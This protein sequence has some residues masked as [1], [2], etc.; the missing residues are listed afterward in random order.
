MMD[1]MKFIGYIDE[2]SNNSAIG[3]A[4]EEIDGLCY[5][6]NVEITLAD[7][8]IFVVNPLLYRPDLEDVGI[9]SGCFGFKF[10]LEAGKTLAGS[11]FKFINGETIPFGDNAKTAGLEELQDVDPDF[12]SG[13]EIQ[14]PRV[15]DLL[16]LNYSSR[17]DHL[18]YAQSDID[19]QEVKT[20]K[21]VCIYVTYSNRLYV[22]N[23]QKQQIAALQEA[24]YFV[25][26]VMA[27]DNYTGGLH[28]NILGDLTIVKKNVGYDFGSWWVGFRAITDIM[29]QEKENVTHIALCNDSFFGAISKNEIQSIESLNG[30]LVGLVDSYQRSHH[31][32]S[33]FLIAKGLYLQS[34]CFHNFISSYP[35]PESKDNVILA[36]EIGLSSDVKLSGSDLAAANNYF[37]LISL[38]VK[39]MDEMIEEEISARETFGVGGEKA[40][41]EK[42]FSDFYEYIKS[43]K[44]VNP[45]HAFWRQIYFSGP[46]IIKRELLFKDP[47]D[48]PNWYSCCMHCI[49][50]PDISL[51]MDELIS[52]LNVSKNQKSAILSGLLRRLNAGDHFNPKKSHTRKG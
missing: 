25:V 32:Q 29:S 52:M 44:I 46:K 23:Y 27:V 13:S 28:G 20:V 48:L 11:T 8:S 3:W 19:L 24:G 7:G 4:V 15:D 12:N 47:M 37:E 50:S 43:G 17:L 49:S 51:E 42:A 9:G 2:I 30:G 45:T 16:S 10:E 18:I 36:G 31:L 38:W 5:D 14:L 26:V 41:I 39:E 34:G 35:F 21:K 6:T 40:D 1:D 22:Y 33:F